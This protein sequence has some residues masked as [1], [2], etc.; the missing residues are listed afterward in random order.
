M[1]NWKESTR[2]IGTGVSKIQSKVQEGFIEITPTI[3]DEGTGLFACTSR[4]NACTFNQ[5]RATRRCLLL[6]N[7]LSNSNYPPFPLLF[8][9]S[10][11][12]EGIIRFYLA[13]D[14]SIVSHGRA[15]LEHPYWLSVNDDSADTLRRYGSA[16]ELAQRIY[17]EKVLFDGF[18]KSYSNYIFSTCICQFHQVF[19]HAH[20]PAGLTRNPRD[21][22]AYTLR[23]MVQRLAALNIIPTYHHSPSAVVERRNIFSNR[24]TSLQLAEQE[25]T[26]VLIH[27][28]I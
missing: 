9:G 1:V 18:M 28:L 7:P 22:K 8:Y 19:F 15:F 11:Y 6:L 2:E 16:F 21:D 24:V 20:V 5:F 12:V 4:C 27:L 13:G 26:I 17:E 3:H 10:P 23:R 25:G 14:D